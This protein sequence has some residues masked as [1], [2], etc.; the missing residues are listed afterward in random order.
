MQVGHLRQWER[1]LSRM[2]HGAL[3]VSCAGLMGGRRA[4]VLQSTVLGLLFGV[5]LDVGSGFR[6]RGDGV[7]GEA[8]WTLVSRRVRDLGVTA[9]TLEAG[10]QVL[11]GG[12][13]GVRGR[14]VVDVQQ[15]RAAVHVRGEALQH[16][17]TSLLDWGVVWWRRDWRMAL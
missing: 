16:R 2:A 13:A 9:P 11:A 17:G 10:P 6:Q 7:Q 1:H 3:A 4:S 15:R 8:G 12:P 14:A 5:A